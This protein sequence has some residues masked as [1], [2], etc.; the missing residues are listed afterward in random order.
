MCRKVY[1]KLPLILKLLQPNQ[2]SIFHEQVKE[3]Q[4]VVLLC[5]ADK[6]SFELIIKTMINKYSHSHWVWRLGGLYHGPI[7]K[8]HQLLDTVTNETVWESKCIGLQEA[9]LN[10]FKSF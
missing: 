10:S 2:I 8:I 3:I 4:N 5:K 6:N 1:K 7:N 9:I